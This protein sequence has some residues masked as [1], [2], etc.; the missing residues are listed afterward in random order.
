ML[1]RMKERHEKGRRANGNMKNPNVIL[2]VIIQA[3]H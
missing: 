1:L 2:V 3:E